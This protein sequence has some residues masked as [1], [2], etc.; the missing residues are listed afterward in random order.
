[1]SDTVTAAT[2][3]DEARRTARTRALIS[4]YVGAASAVALAAVLVFVPTSTD[5]DAFHHVGDYFLTALGIPAVLVVAALLPALRTL[6][7][8]RDGRLG[9]AGIVATCAGALVLTGMFVYGLIAAT[10][11]SLG[12]TYLLASGAM[13]IGVVL[14]AIGSWRT[15]LL[16]RWLLVAWPVAW[17]VGGLLPVLP[18][19]SPLLLAAAYLAMAVT[20]PRRGT[21]TS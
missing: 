8:R 20:L 2:P 5:D 9:M 1:M 6:Q 18:G 10:G 21:T 11:S 3:V 16:P 13:I 7:E 14:F 15:G 12:P 4:L 19:P 17:A